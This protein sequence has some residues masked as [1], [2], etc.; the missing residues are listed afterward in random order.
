MRSNGDKDATLGN[1]AL[2]YY[3]EGLTQS[4]IARR[5]GVS[6]ATIVNM[7]RDARERGLVEIRVEG[8]TLAASSL[9]RRL[10][11]AYGLEDCYVAQSG[12]PDIGLDR[13]GALR[14]LGRVAAAAMLEIAQPGDRIGVAWGETVL[15]LAGAMPRAD[16]ADATVYQ[17]IGSMV[18]DRV[19]ASEECAIRIA[20]RLG[21]TCYT[22]HAPAVVGDADLAA[23]LRAEPTIRTQLE[24]LHALDMTVA[25]VGNVTPGTHFHAAGMVS[26]VDL[27]DAARRGARGI[28]C[29]RYIDADGR[30]LA[31][32]KPDERVIGI[33]LDDL[34]RARKRLLVVAGR[35]RT[36]ATSAC[37]RGGLVT[38]L[39]VDEPL[40]TALLEA[41]GSPA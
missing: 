11:E 16:I 30:G 9:A 2:L 1:V 19:P 38:H 14:Q 22:L 12:S 26:D 4:D 39:C 15:A 17:I 24:A 20:N 35:D 25:S 29:C 21:A 18:S 7:L 6:R 8:R 3:G 34:G 33:T 5:M 31:G 23:R 41:G 37:L 36:D 27:A 32:A 28:I 40:A 10:R 13:A